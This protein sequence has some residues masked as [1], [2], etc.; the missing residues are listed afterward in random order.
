M[1]RFFSI[2]CSTISV[3]WGPAF[4]VDTST[5]IYNFAFFFKVLPHRSNLAGWLYSPH[6]PCPTVPRKKHSRSTCHP[7]HRLTGLHEGQAP[8]QAPLPKCSPA[9]LGYQ[10]RAGER[11]R[12]NG[13]DGS[14]LRA[15]EAA[16]LTGKGTAVWQTHSS[17]AG[18]WQWVGQHQCLAVDCTLSNGRNSKLSC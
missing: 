12:Q 14:E 2:S 1:V 6:T 13:R 9:A 5:I 16:V 7:S 3:P 10:R 11:H 4:I 8:R 17:G 15:V 18:R